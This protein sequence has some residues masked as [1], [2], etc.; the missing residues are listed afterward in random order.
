MTQASTHLRRP[1]GPAPRRDLI[2]PTLPG[3]LSKI[4]DDVDAKFVAID[5]RLT[6]VGKSLGITFEPSPE[7]DAAMAKIRQRVGA[8]T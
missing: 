3:A 7:S 6:A 4:F 2:K 5:D 8:R 1:P